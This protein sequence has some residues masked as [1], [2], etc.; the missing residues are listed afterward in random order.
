MCCR[1][2]ELDPPA[3]ISLTQY[4]TSDNDAT[5]WFAN[6]LPGSTQRRFMGHVRVGDSNQ[7]NSGR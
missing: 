3:E 1:R 2:R 6:Y 4:R 7:R 5:S